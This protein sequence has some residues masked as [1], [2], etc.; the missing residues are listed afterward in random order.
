ML[1]YKLTHFFNDL[2]EQIKKEH[3]GKLIDRTL[4]E[5]TLDILNDIDCY[6]FENDILKDTTYYYV[7]AQSWTL[8]ECHPYYMVKVNMRT[9]SVI[10]V[11]ISALCHVLLID[12]YS[13]IRLRSIG[14]ERRNII[15]CTIVMSISY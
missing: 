4:L 6:Y 15:I 1:A 5:N 2:F 3:E 8:K 10:N 14:S 12:G 9:P 7:E 13:L 11:L